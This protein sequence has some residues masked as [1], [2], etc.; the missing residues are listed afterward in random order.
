MLAPFWAD[1]TGEGDAGAGSGRDLRGH[2]QWRW[3]LWVVVEFRLNA[4]GTDD[5]KVFQVW[6]G[7]NGEQD[8]TFNYDP[9]HT[10]LD[11]L[12][13]TEDGGGLT[14]GAENEDG[15]GGDQVDETEEE[16]NL[17]AVDYSIV[18]TDPEPGDS[19]TMTVEA[20]GLTPGVST[21]RSEA[22]SPIVSGV[23]RVES[24]VEVIRAATENDAYVAAVFNDLLGRDPSPF[25]LDRWVTRLERG[26]STRL[27]FTTALTNTDEWRGLVVDRFYD[28][29]LDRPPTAGERATQIDRLDAGLAEKTLVGR[30]AGSGEFFTAA[31]GTNDGFVDLLFDRLLG[32]DPSAAEVDALVARI[33]GGTSRRT[34]ATSVYQR[35]ESRNL[36]VEALY[37]QYLHHPPSAARRAHFA[38]KLKTQSDTWVTTRLV[39]SQEYFDNAT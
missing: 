3:Q 12:V 30:L 35:L 32:R 24:E 21:V 36:R 9:A 13:L 17:P 16:D 7:L 11:G 37:D 19:V 28:Q 23:T 22:T 8:I 4:F 31:G 6:I 14:I 29:I 2:G 10:N 34:V 38:E 20:E 26:T 33:D 18:S 25:E 5:L 15:S 39:S 1:L 27:Q